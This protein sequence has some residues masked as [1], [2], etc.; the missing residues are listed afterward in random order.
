[1]YIYI[2]IHIYIY[3]YIYIYMLGGQKHMP[4]DG[5]G[6]PAPNPRYL[7]RWCLYYKLV[8]ITFV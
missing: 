7:V 1:M 6:T 8:D 2:Y 5:L 3:I 4:T